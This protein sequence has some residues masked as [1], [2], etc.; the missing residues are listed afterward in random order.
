LTTSS[1]RITAMKNSKFNHF[2]LLSGLNNKWL[3]ST[4]AIS[5]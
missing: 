2:D 1:S 4:S 3:Y 5:A